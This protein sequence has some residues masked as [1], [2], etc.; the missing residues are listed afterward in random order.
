MRFARTSLVVLFLVG[1]SARSANADILA[2]EV[3]QEGT[4]VVLLGGWTIGWEFTPTVDISVT[5]LGVYDHGRDGLNMNHI[6]RL[7]DT[8]ETSSDL[9]SVAFGVGTY[10]LTDGFYLVDISPVPLTA[11]HSYVVS[12]Y[13]NTSGGAGLSHRY[14]YSGAS[15]TTL[16]LAPEVGVV[17]T[18]RRYLAGNGYPSLTSGNYPV[19]LG[20]SFA[21]TTAIPEPSTLA[22]LGGLLAMGLLGRW[23]RRR[24]SLIY[25]RVS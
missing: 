24:S 22:A 13:A 3:P 18:D 8:A 19:P 23:W 14:T 5:S 6:V 17:T 15:G 4:Y 25:H 10:D 21:F 20:P 7:W 9:A 11:G 16:A 12:T 2:V 1:A